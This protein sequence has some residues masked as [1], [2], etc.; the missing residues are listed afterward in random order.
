M[1]VVLRR[2]LPALFFVLLWCAP[3]EARA[4]PQ[5]RVE[6]KAPGTGAIRSVTVRLTDPDSGAPINGAD[7]TAIATMTKPHLMSMPPLHLRPEGGGRYA[8][9]VRFEMLSRWTVTM[10]VA[11][12]D[13]V[14]FFSAFDVD[15]KTSSPDDAFR[16]VGPQGSGESP[17]IRRGFLASMALAVLGGLAAL[18]LWRRQRPKAKPAM[19]AAPADGGAHGT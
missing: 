8:S 9:R 11:R 17:W 2:S 13:F 14:P 7:V 10:R 3:A 4:T 1:G 6:V 18:L 19:P 12:R 5:P 16:V 15:A